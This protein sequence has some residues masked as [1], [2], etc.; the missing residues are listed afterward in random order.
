MKTLKISALHISSPLCYIFNNAILAG[1][2]PVRAK[3]SIVTPIYEKGDK[4]NYRP[5]SLLTSFSK[6]FKK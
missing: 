4:A 6:V 3:Y 2:F 1:K 5:I